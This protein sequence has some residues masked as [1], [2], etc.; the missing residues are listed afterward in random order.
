MYNQYYGTASLN[1][2]MEIGQAFQ[3]LV[4]ELEH[5]QVEFD[6]MRKVFRTNG[7]VRDGKFVVGRGLVLC[8]CAA[9]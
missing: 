3:D 8:R 6:L 7:S 4:T 5:A 2:A 9:D 1:R